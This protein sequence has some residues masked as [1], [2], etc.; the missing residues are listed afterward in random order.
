[1]IFL[2][3]SVYIYIIVGVVVAL[4]IITQRAVVL[5]LKCKAKRTARLESLSLRAQDQ[6]DSS[7]RYSSS[8]AVKISAF[9][10]IMN[11]TSN[12]DDNNIYETVDEVRNAERETSPEPN[13]SKRPPLPLP[14]HSHEAILLGLAPAGPRR[15]PPAPVCGTYEA[16]YVLMN[17][18]KKNNLNFGTILFDPLKTN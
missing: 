1:M 10:R 15:P 8:P 16:P 9:S 18:H 5:Y 6:D 4:I 14:I 2:L 17:R 11:R 13:I 3:L 7:K 12:R